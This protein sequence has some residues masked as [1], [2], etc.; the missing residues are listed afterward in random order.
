MQGGGIYGAPLPYAK[1]SMTTL[2]IIGFIHLA[3]GAVF[4]PD[5][6]EMA[7]DSQETLEHVGILS[8][9]CASCARPARPTTPGARA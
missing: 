1:N 5:L 3:G 8:P 9:R 4:S 2:T 7:L 6:S